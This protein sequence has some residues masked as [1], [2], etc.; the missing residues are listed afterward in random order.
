MASDDIPFPPGLGVDDIVAWGS[1]GLVV[2]E[3]A[4]ETVS[5]VKRHEVNSA[6]RLRWMTQI[7]DAL[8]FI[9]DAVIIHGDLT[10]ANVLL[11]DEL[12]AKLSDFAGSSIDSLPLLT[13]VPPSYQ[14]PKDLLSIHGDMFAFAALMYELTIGKRPYADLCETDIEALFEKGEF[15]DVASL[16][17]LGDIIRTCWKGGYESTHLLLKDLKLIQDT[18]ATHNQGNTLP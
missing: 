2:L 5:F 8:A 9:H 13:Q 12:N 7:A 15:P 3:S 16:G 17:S 18:A 14:Y 1:T 11:D 10:P 4:T 6:L